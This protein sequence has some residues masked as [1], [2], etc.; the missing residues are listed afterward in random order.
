LLPKG[1]SFTI[2]GNSYIKWDYIVKLNEKQY[3]EKLHCACKIKNWHIFFQNEKMKVFL[4]AQV[5]STSSSA[6]LNY[7]ENEINDINFKGAS[8]TAKFCKIFNDIFDLLNSKNKYCKTPGR[9]GVAEK[10]LSKL[11]QKIYKYINYI[12]KLEITT[13]ISA[14]QKTKN[15]ENIQNNV[16]KSNEHTIV[17]RSVLT[18]L[19]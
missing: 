5:L 13:F 1:P 10:D 8:A 11:K 12:E 15:K 7:L 18:C 14:K 6:S 19:H 4:A 9:N 16:N 17:R 2:V 3:E